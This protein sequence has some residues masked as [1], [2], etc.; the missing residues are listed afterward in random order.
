MHD[1]VY[2]NWDKDT[3][4]DFWDLVDRVDETNRRIRAAE[5]QKQLFK[6]EKYKALSYR[7]GLESMSL[8]L[9]DECEKVFEPHKAYTLR[10]KVLYKK[11]ISMANSG[12]SFRVI[13]QKVDV[14]YS[15]IYRWIKE[16]RSISNACNRDDEDEL[17]CRDMVKEA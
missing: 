12:L 13:S 9:S 17:Q 5:I 6:A 8:I 1:D 15:T 4:D 16:D 10:K 7:V 14:H 3:T 2:H 11:V